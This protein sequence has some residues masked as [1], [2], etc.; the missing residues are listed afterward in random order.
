MI[1]TRTAKERLD[2]STADISKTSGGSVMLL[3]CIGVGWKSS[4]W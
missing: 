1:A 2:T 3:D 4:Y